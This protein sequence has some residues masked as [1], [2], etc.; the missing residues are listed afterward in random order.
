MAALGSKLRRALPVLLATL[1]LLQCAAPAWA[2]GRL[3]HRVI[4]KLAER[5]LTDRA[6]AEIKAL[7]E[8]GDSLA[9]CSTWADEHRRELPKTAPWHDLARRGRSRR[10]TAT[11]ERDR[12]GRGGPARIPIRISILGVDP[13]SGPGHPSESA[14]GRGREDDLHGSLDRP[15][16]SR[17]RDSPGLRGWPR[18]PSTPSDA[19]GMQP[20]RTGRVPRSRPLC[21]ASRPGPRWSA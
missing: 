16:S 20:G 4:A 18:G 7:L 9:D 6:K 2:W 17:G 3:G 13:R 19:L 11:V 15:T 8:P 5:H 21:F 14:M 12:R 1:L 10:G